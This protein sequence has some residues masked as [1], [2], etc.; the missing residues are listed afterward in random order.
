MNSQRHLQTERSLGPVRVVAHDPI[1]RVIDV[2]RAVE[3]YQRLGFKTEYHDQTYAFAHFG[4]LTVHLAHHDSVWP[5]Y[6]PDRPMTSVLYIHVEDADRL[7]ADWRAAG[8][9]VD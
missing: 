5:G 8:A 2:A 1:F 3:H 7:A 9:T 6:H 4:T